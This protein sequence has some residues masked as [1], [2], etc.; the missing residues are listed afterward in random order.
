MLNQEQHY[1]Q[2][3]TFKTALAEGLC[4]LAQFDPALKAIDEALE[5]IGQKGDSFD[6]PEILRVKGNIILATTK[7]DFGDAETCLQDSLRRARSERTLGWELRTA[8]S[9]AALKMSK[10][11]GNIGPG[12][13]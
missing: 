9:L 1:I 6:V 13:A 7:S 4:A 2:V 10:V 8:I 11:N 3:A 5:V 12:P